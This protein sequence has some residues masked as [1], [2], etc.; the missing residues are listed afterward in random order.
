MSLS[1]LH[2]SLNFLVCKSFNG[3]LDYEGMMTYGAS[4]G[5]GAVPN[6]YFP[7]INLIASPT[8]YDGAGVK[9]ED[10]GAGAFTPYHDRAGVA[11]SSIAPG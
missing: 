7:L 8:Q 10:P 6:C 2:D 1:F 3:H 11:K 5:Y 4:F 9:R